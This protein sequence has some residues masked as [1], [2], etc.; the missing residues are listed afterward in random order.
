MADG[1]RA[2][3]ALGGNALLTGDG[4]AEEQ[5]AVVEETART[6]ADAVEAGYE[7]VVTHGNGPQVGALMLQQESAPETPRMPLDVLVAE[8][9]A[10]VGYVL[11]QALGNA[12]GAPSATVVTQVVVDSDDPAFEDPTKPVGPWYTAEEAREKP[13]E[14][15]DVGEG[16]RSH[17]R[18]VPS[19]QPRGVVESGEIGMLADE[20]VTVVCGGGGGVPVV[21]GDDGLR[22][23]EAVVDKDR[24]SRLVAET[25]EA[26]LLVFLTDV[27][28]A[29]VDY[30]DDDERPLL[31]V[32]ADE[33]RAH[34]EAGEFGVGTM[35]PKVEAALGFVESNEGAE[36]V[37]T[38][39]ESF[40]DAL[41]GEAGTR[42][43]D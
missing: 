3:V 34:L 1:T 8:T 4:G 14:T 22:G 36:A 18:V 6:V 10:Q 9:Q 2:V 16:A 5:R 7:V 41:D 31:R 27:E 42:L 35:R 17:R 26:E 21:R 32:D 15:R 38:T 25:V 24:T 30:G 40:E 20:G 43:R 37:I 19:P 13:F 39:P 28:H 12:T 29:Y 23:V 11:Q 33:L